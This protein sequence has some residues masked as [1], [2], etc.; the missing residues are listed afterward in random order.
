MLQNKVYYVK[1]NVIVK[2]TEMLLLTVVPITEWLLDY[3]DFMSQALVIVWGNS[4][5]KSI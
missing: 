1:V 5:I 4:M 3:S 2:C